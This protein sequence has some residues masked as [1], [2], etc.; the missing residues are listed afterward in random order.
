MS[1][2]LVSCVLLFHEATTTEVLRSFAL[3][4]LV[5]ISIRRTVFVAEFLLSGS[6]I[7]R[8]VCEIKVKLKENVSHSQKSSG[9]IRKMAR[10]EGTRTTTSLSLYIVARPC[11]EIIQK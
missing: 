9:A 10:N 11:A 2:D 1:R 8:L 5:S 4:Y 3:A 7:G 6:R